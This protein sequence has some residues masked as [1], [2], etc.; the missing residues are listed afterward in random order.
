[1][2]GPLSSQRYRAGQCERFSQ[3]AADRRTV[4]DRSTAQCDSERRIDQC[5]RD[6]EPGQRRATT[7]DEVLGQRARDRWSC[8][9]RPTGQGETFGERTRDGGSG[10]RWAGAEF[11]VL[12]DGAGDTQP[13]KCGA[14][15]R[16]KRLDER[17][18]F[19]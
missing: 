4:E 13:R 18:G 3:R 6:T 19:T 16:D 7:E 5:A 8:Q 15:T 10:K 11:E 2:L 1:M 14:A 12:N 9:G 17:A